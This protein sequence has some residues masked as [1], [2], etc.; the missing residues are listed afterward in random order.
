MTAAA[1]LLSTTSSPLEAAI[2]IVAGVASLAIA[3]LNQRFFWLKGWNSG[4][5]PAPLWVGRLMF[6]TFG[7]LAILV[8]VRDLW[9]QN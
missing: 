3:F 2:F 9:F 7:V 1:W 5:K 4:G 8:G 6:G